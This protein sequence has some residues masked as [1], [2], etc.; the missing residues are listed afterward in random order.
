MIDGSRNEGHS[1][2]RAV[3]RGNSFLQRIDEIIFSVEKFPKG[4]QKGRMR[5]SYHVVTDMTTDWSQCCLNVVALFE[6]PC[7]L[8][9]LIKMVWVV[10][11]MIL[12][13]LQSTNIN[14]QQHNSE[15]IH[16]KTSIKGLVFRSH[17]F[18][19]VCSYYLDDVL[20]FIIYIRFTLSLSYS[21]WYDIFFYCL[22]ICLLLSR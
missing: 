4:Y 11:I 7:S 20:N 3:I 15:H 16:D 5:M 19:L 10:N 14:K 1:P 9:V 22:L 12:Q 13:K 6:F 17:S 2:T 18:V 21:L 8:L